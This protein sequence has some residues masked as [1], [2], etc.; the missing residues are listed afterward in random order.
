LVEGEGAALVFL[1]VA[2]LGSLDGGRSLA[3]IVSDLSRV[4]LELV[5]VECDGLGRLLDSKVNCY[6]ALVSPWCMRL[7]IEEGDVVVG[8]L[9]T[10]DIC[11]AMVFLGWCRL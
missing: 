7:E 3:G 6:A 8:W 11:L 4:D 9:D 1:I 5:G 2:D 10:G